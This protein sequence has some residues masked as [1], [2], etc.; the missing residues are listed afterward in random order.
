MTEMMAAIR[1]EKCSE[2][3]FSKNKKK[4][5]VAQE[6]RCFNLLTRKVKPYK[7]FNH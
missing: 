6:D 5:K 4:K 7:N 1:K 2:R 3:D